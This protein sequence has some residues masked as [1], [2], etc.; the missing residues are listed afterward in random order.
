MQAAA[1]KTRTVLWIMALLGVSML[2]TG[3][4]PYDINRSEFPDTVRVEPVYAVS[5]TTVYDDGVGVLYDG[6]DYYYVAVSVDG[7]PLTLTVAKLESLA[8]V[9]IG[10]TEQLTGLEQ[11]VV[12]LR[13]LS[14]PGGTLDQLTEGLDPLTDPGAESVEI[15]RLGIGTA[16]L[17][18]ES[19]S[20][21]DDVAALDNFL[22]GAVAT[23]VAALD[24]PGAVD[25]AGIAAA[26]E[27]A[28]DAARLVAVYYLE[29]AQADCGVCSGGEPVKV[30]EAESSLQAGDLERQNPDPDLETVAELYGSSVDK[31][32]Q[33]IGSC[34]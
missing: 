14:D 20:T 3:A 1:G 7:T 2:A 23:L 24:D 4:A 18:L 12:L 34:N 15:A 19:P 17:A 28:V 30:C 21:I 8:T 10:I 22:K 33:S 32:L 27:E 11:A 13:G 5:Q 31:S 25:P 16:W 6:V 29:A 9:R 26:S